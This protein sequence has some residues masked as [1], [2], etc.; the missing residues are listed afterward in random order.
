MIIKSVTLENFGL[1]QGTHTISFEVVKGKAVT[2][3]GGLNGRGKTTF[4]DAITL[5]LYGRRALKYLQD[6]RIRYSQYLVN[7][8]NKSAHQDAVSGVSLVLQEA[9]A[10]REEVTIRRFWSIPQKGEAVD[11]FVAYRNGTVDT[12]LSENWDYY[13]EEL[14]PLNI[15]R[16]FFFDNEKIAQIAD[17][18]SFE[19]V[20]ESIRALLGL[21]TIDQLTS[22]MHK[23]SRRAI[24]NA[25]PEGKSEFIQLAAETHA[26]ID[27]CEAESKETQTKAA[28]CRQIIVRAQSEYQKAEEQFWK[29]GGNLGLQRDQIKKERQ[30]L[31]EKRTA[32]EER[33][34][35]YLV[36]SVTPL[37]VCRPLVLLAYE[38]AAESERRKTIKY[39]ESIIKMLKHLLSEGA[40]PQAFAREAEAF[41]DS[42]GKTFRKSS[43][44]SDEHYGLS[45]M[46]HGLIKSFVEQG[47]NTLGEMKRL[48]A[49]NRQIDGKI[50][51]LD[52]H[53]SFE[54]SENEVRNLWNKMQS[55]TTEIIQQESQLRVEEERFISLEKRIEMLRNR[56][57]RHLEKG[58]LFDQSQDESIRI[59]Q[60]AVIT[61]EVMEEFKK[62]IQIKRVKEL[63]NKI[64][65]CS[66]FMIQKESIIQRIEIDP[67][68]L[69][70]CLV[71][72]AGG[73]LLKSQ[74][75]AGEK[76]LFAVSI[77]WGLAQSSGYDMPVIVDTPLGRLDSQHRTSFVE[78]YL[79][80]A[81]QQVI[82]LSTD[83]EINGR[84]FELI[85]PRVNAV[86]TLVYDDEAKSTSI[87]EGYF[88]GE[89]V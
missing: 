77:L 15:S 11:S 60:Y 36:N 65:E 41:L 47:S 34:R 74:L 22:D 37:F 14:L 55:L 31:L 53:L 63:E 19:S 64:H 46:S 27:A 58:R 24:N 67:D 25:L 10:P 86:Y 20:K 83:E 81:A 17:D 89:T 87:S 23:L 56:Y 39:S 88:G 80:Y 59:A 26:E 18:D 16:F 33:I 7:H 29:Q 12:Y 21:T 84:Y 73:E 13:V 28:H 5:A 54:A 62:R 48:L 52:I 79:P 42:A 50:A 6:E 78:R 75:S 35:D 82:V 72:Y 85:R 61:V 38:R 2:L 49:E 44:P 9:S 70:I 32:N 69:D 71:D 45:T 30:A 1:Y 8:I 4:L 76:Q 57:N 66:C 40:Y 51:Q 68:T 43:D 3:I